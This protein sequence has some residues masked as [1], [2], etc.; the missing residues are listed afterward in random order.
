MG[1][2]VLTCST[3]QLCEGSSTAVEKHRIRRKCAACQYTN[4]Q[5]Y[6]YL[7]T[8]EEAASVPGAQ[9]SSES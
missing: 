9:P 6:E 2:D 1:I 4:I 5:T 8:G 3:Q 7:N